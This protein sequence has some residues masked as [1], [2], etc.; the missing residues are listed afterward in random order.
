MSESLKHKKLVLKMK[1]Y[2]ENNY[3]IVS[4]LLKCDLP[5]FSNPPKI[6]HF[7][8]D[9][10]YKC[11]DSIIIGEA[12]T[13]LDFDREHSLKQYEAFL[14]YCDTYS[15]KGIF[16]IIVPWTE[17]ASAHNLFRRLKMNFGFKCHI[18]V[19]NEIFEEIHI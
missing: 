3:S 13:S 4:E 17:F 16:F 2:I 5:E 6:L 12:K 7:V 1:E 11:E 15:E 10:F 18:I 19:L 8:P 9:I 14:K